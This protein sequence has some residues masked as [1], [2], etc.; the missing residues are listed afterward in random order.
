MGTMIT[1]CAYA[2][3]SAPTSPH[4]KPPTSASRVWGG[5]RQ[6]WRAAVVAVMGVIVVIGRAFDADGTAFHPVPG[7][8]EAAARNSR[9]GSVNPGSAIPTWPSDPSA[10]RFGDVG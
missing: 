5:I 10:M 8:L 4:A 3:S 9:T 2:N 7:R 1:A 6:R